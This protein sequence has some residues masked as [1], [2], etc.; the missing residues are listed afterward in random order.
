MGGD[1]LTIVEKSIEIDAETDRIWPL[2]KW[3][4]IPK[5]FT[6]FKDATPTSA[7]QNKVG[8]KLHVTSEVANTENS[9]D[10]EITEYTVSGEGSRAWKTTGGKMQAVGAIYLKPEGNRTQMYMVGEYELPYGAIGRMMDRIRVKKTFEESFEESS[11]R[12]KEIAESA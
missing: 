1:V 11:K 3:D 10:I 2:T 5:W 6:L 9:M 4:K 8:S 7:E 12:L